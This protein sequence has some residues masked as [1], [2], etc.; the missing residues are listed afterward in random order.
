L[1]ITAAAPSTAH[2]TQ[3]WGEKHNMPD[4][5]PLLLCH[6]FGSADVVAGNQ[7]GLDRSRNHERSE[8]QRSG[9]CELRQRTEPTVRKLR[10]AKRELVK[11]KHNQGLAKRIPMELAPVLKN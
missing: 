7:S 11:M 1:S 8:V 3:V 5:N 4:I 10:R 6:R 2:P 9:R